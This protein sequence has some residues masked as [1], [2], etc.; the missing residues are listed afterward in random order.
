MKTEHIKRLAQFKSLHE[1]AKMAAKT[2]F[3]LTSDA[4]EVADALV[5][6]GGGTS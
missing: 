3:A 2:G 6:A 1:K 5:R 4:A